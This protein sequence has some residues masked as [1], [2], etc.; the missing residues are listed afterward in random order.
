MALPAII[1]PS[2]AVVAL[3]ESVSLCQSILEYKHQT[4][5][6]DMQR[7]QMHRQ[8]D[9]AMQQLIQEH[10]TNM[11]RLEGTFNTH[12]ETVQ[13]IA[14]KNSQDFDVLKHTQRQI[15]DCLKAICDA[16]TPEPVRLALSQGMTSLS[17]NQG[18]V[19]NEYIKN[20]NSLT[21]AHIATLDSLHDSDQGR[22]F[23]DV[24]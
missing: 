20:T 15:D 23:T 12:K 11:T 8:A 22:T 17:Q 2:F 4:Q 6:I 21:N 9:T 13:S 10:K 1:A 5:Q 16:A 19:L 14:A 3:K 18:A 7:E 24:S